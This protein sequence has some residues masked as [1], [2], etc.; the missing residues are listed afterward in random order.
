[1]GSSYYLNI[2]SIRSKNFYCK[3][4]CS[5]FSLLICQRLKNNDDNTVWSNNPGQRGFG[6]FFLMSSGVTSF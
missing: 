4:V 1:M 2:D 5:R 6:F 3:F